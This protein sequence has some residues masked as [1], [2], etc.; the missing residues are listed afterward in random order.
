[1]R[2]DLI[3]IL[4]RDLLDVHELRT[5]LVNGI[6]FVNEE[7]V[8]G[9]V[10]VWEGQDGIVVLNNNLEKCKKLFQGNCSCVLQAFHRETA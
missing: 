10:Q 4:E 8:W 2:D 7:S 5:D 9:L 3:D 1:M 6:I